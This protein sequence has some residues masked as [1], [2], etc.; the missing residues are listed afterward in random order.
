MIKVLMAAVFGARLAPLGESVVRFRVWPNDLDV[1]LHMNNGRYLTIMDLGRLDLMFR[2]G[3]G[4]IIVKRRWRPMVGT[5]VIRYRRGLAPFERYELK[6]RIVSWDEKWFWLEQRFERD[7]RVIAIGVLKGLFRDRVGNVA[8]ADVL[9]A[10][11]VTDAPQTSDGIL[12]WQHAD[13]ATTQPAAPS[14]RSGDAAD[15]DAR[16]ALP[17]AS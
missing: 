4:G 10:L 7:G 6:T 8:T 13:A 16:P 17:S 5:A 11:G 14:Q 9:A 15:E 12:A 3:L 1:N 2:T